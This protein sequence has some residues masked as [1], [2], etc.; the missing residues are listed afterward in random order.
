MRFTFQCSALLF[1]FF[2]LSVFFPP[3]TFASDRCDEWVGKI[4][5]VQGSVQFRGKGETQWATAQFSNTFCPGDM[6]RVQEKGR[7]AI[8]LA[9]NTLI[10]IDQN[11][12]ITFT[13]VEKKEVSWIDLLSGAVHFIS[14][15]PRSLKV[16]TPFV[17]G[18]VE[19]TEFYVRVL[20]DHAVFT[21][22]EGT[23]LASNQ[24]GT[25]TL[26][27]GESALAREGEAPVPHVVVRPRDAVQWALYY[28]PVISYQADELPIAWESIQRYWQGDL[29][30]AFSVIRDVPEGVGDA[31]FFNYRAALLLSVGRVEE[32]EKDIGQA[33][34]L[35]PGNSDSIALQSII[36]VVQNEKDRALNLAQKSVEADPGSATAKIALSYARQAGFDL[37][38]AL[39]GLKDAVNMR[40][41][42]SLAWAR[43]SELQLSFGKLDKALESAE[44]AV[45]L[46]P[47][48]SRTQTVLGYAYLSQVKTDAAKEAF[49][50]AIARD[51][52]DPLPR[53]GLGLAMIRKG[54]LAE[55]R[56]EI[57]I[58]TSL[59][60]NNSLMRSYAGKAYYEEK[61][62]RVA[63]GQYEMAKELD[64]LDPTPYFYDAIRKQTINRPVEALHDLQK[65]I[66]LNDNRAVYRSKQLLDDDL[67]SRSASLA[68]IYNDLGFEQLALVEG[69]KSVNTDPG[70][71]SAHRLL[72]D[73]YSA[74]PRHETAR[75]S[76]LL[77]SQLLQPLNVTPVQPQLAEGGLLIL[78]GAGPGTLSFNEFNPLFHRSKVSLQLSSVVGDNKT[79]GDELV[80]SGVHDNISISAG[81]FHYETDG[82]RE[83]NDLKKDIYNVF[84]QA[85]LSNKTGIQ[86]EYRHNNT[87]HG[88]LELTFTGEYTPDQ[89]EEELSDSIRFGLNHAVSNDSNLLA[90]FMYKNADID[91]V[92]F[93]GIF[94]IFSDY[95]FYMG[96]VQYIFQ[97]E[98]FHVQGGIGYR[99]TDETEVI[100]FFG[101][102]EKGDLH[103]EFIDVYLYSHIDLPKNINLTIGGSGNFHDGRYDDRDQFNPK[104]GLT[105]KPLPDTT[106]RAAAFRTLQ[107]PGISVQEVE[108][109]LEPTQVAGFNQFFLGVEGARE[110]RYGIGIDQK[111]EN[112]IFA[113]AEYSSREIES[114]I[115]LQSGFQFFDR[116]EH[117][118]RAYIY[119][120]PYRC[121]ALK[122]EYSYERFKR[123]SSLGVTGVEQFTSLRTH[124][125][126]IEGRYFHPSG[127]SAGMKATYV[128]QEGDFT[129]P[130]P[131]SPVFTIES[132]DDDFWIVDASIGYRLPKRHG[133]I[134]L[135]AKNLFDKSFQ[136][137][138]TDP[139]NP[140]IMPDRLILLKFTLAI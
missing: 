115:L 58:A 109:T 6:L 63:M 92:A 4:V 97:A 30:G 59:D 76:E 5:S 70:N 18:T 124:R 20:Q 51:Q 75:V 86:A 104:F 62:D 65:S 95:D 136:F 1:V 43:L 81:Q 96:E 129:V 25:L 133:V 11:T 127:F 83:N 8:Y 71:Y 79:F 88:D 32:A 131:M 29:T 67:A 36:A 21:V 78:D 53:L 24:A 50:K 42:N 91:T 45:Q 37:E 118:G 112:N 89:R 106:V 39:A 26:A 3:D 130:V 47:D 138:D 10:R 52:A 41:E 101:F 85:R 126:P 111:F 55:G 102:P 113:G 114:P 13:E 77:Q 28:P 103:S 15:V 64:P 139:R 56:E 68:R 7:A 61:R 44:K 69:W 9:N 87:I 60:P 54:Q 2:L 117:V 120:T 57:E 27:G 22:F 35:S 98:R 132:G 100:S 73:S 46:N 48:L 94:E 14:R 74:L 31:R 125:V 119:W 38:G 108:P 33:L 72:A 110:W 82:F 12:T 90:S 16:S 134:S 140:R 116:N 34:N 123:E 17:D 23:V 66:E 84:A 49:T 93:P 99:D 105:W 107:K 80:I 122:T 135:E 121:L 40:P 19:G 137:Q 128:K